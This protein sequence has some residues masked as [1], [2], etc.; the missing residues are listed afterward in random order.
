MQASG[1]RILVIG[2]RSNCLN[3]IDCLLVS[4]LQGW[5]SGLQ[6]TALHPCSTSANEAG[7]VGLGIHEDFVLDASIGQGHKPFGTLR[8]VGLFLK[9]SSLADHW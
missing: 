2:C 6:E 7:V 1:S 3:G 8:A 5:R 9:R 4:W